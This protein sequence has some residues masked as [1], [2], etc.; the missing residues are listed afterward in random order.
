MRGIIM[1]STF[2]DHFQIALL[3]KAVKRSH[4][5]TGD[6]VATLDLEIQL[7]SAQTQLERK[8]DVMTRR[9]RKVHQARAARK[10]QEQAEKEWLAK[11]ARSASRW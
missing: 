8:L 2:S 3:K 4:L 7:A 6:S 10:S 9:A 5:K 1:A 11:R